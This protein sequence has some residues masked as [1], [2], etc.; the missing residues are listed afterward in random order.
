[1]IVWGSD[2][3]DLGDKIF[4]YFC[5]RKDKPPYQFTEIPLGSVSN[6]DSKRIHYLIRNGCR[7]QNKY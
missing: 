5:P 7:L 1:M 6:S 4:R 3:D 2:T